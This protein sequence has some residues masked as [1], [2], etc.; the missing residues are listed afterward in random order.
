MGKFLVGYRLGLLRL[1]VT[2]VRGRKDICKNTHADLKLRKWLGSLGKR[3]N[4][5]KIE[6]ERIGNVI[7]FTVYTARPQVDEGRH[8]DSGY[9]R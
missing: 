7:R 3:R 8:R 6:I 1:G 9:T 2:L 4:R 5:L